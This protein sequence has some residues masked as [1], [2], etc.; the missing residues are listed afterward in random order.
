MQH[1]CQCTQHMFS[2]TAQPKYPCQSTQH[3]TSCTSQ[4]MR[5]PPATRMS[6]FTSQTAPSR[7]I[8]C[9]RPSERLVKLQA[10]THTHRHT[11]AHTRTRPWASWTTAAQALCLNLSKMASRSLPLAALY[12]VVA[13]VR[14][15]TFHSTSSF[16]AMYARTR[17]CL[18]HTHMHKCEWPPATGSLVL[19][20]EGFY[21]LQRWLLVHGPA[22]LRPRA[23][24]CRDTGATSTWV[25]VQARVL[26]AQP[27]HGV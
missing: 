3:T 19:T 14:M 15:G 6:S 18:P 10:S 9:T 20:A 23:S 12:L 1:P 8:S 21:L 4:P 24:A 22:C 16:C 13:A 27:Q 11:H 2:C 7:P 25:C 5:H 26:D 17:A